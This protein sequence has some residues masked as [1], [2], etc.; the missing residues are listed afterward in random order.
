MLASIRR[1]FAHRGVLEVETPLLCESAATEPNLTFFEASYRTSGNTGGKQLYLQTSPEFA[2]KRLLA[3]GLGS[4]YQICKAFRNSERGRNHN[5][6]FTMLEW[7]RVGF[8]LTELMDEVEAIMNELYQTGAELAPSTRHSYPSLFQH[9]TGLHPLE[10]TLDQFTD[11]AVTHGLP[12]AR[13]LCGNDRAVWLDLLFDRMIQP[14]LGTKSLCFVYG[15]PALFPSMARKMLEDSRYV[16]RVEVFLNGIEIGNGFHELTDPLEQRERFKQDL[17]A[18]SLIQAQI[19][20]QDERFLSAMSH[21]I[22]ECSGIALGLDRILMQL[23]EAKSID[24]VLSF[25]VEIA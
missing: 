1:F 15:Y 22:P 21:G 19:P 8:S 4:I 2:M 5:P 9:Y 25:P 3:S 10:S 14:K 16:E 12:E 6:E 13:Q 24:E 20:P 23:V 11:F 7:Y 18:R 17:E